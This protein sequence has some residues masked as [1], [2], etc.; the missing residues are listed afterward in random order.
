M[1][2]RVV[3][4]GVDEETP[5]VIGKPIATNRAEILEN[6][7]AWIRIVTKNLEQHAA[8]LTDGQKAMLKKYPDSYRIDVYPTHR[9]AAARTSAGSSPGHRALL[10]PGCAGAPMP[11]AR[12]PA[13]GPASDA[14]SRS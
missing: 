9:T 13:A 3:I 4:I 6:V 11:E 12:G 8:K 5:R 1:S 14:E 10:S 2:D 7:D